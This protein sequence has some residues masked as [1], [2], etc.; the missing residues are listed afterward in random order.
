MEAV[1][2]KTELSRFATCALILILVCAVRT[3]GQE[4]PPVAPDTI[5][6]TSRDTYRLRVENAQYGRV[7]ISVDCG[8]HFMLVGRVMTP[9]SLAAADR[10]AQQAG[11]IVRS[12]SAGIA[13]AIGPGQVL[14]ILPKPA[15]A[16][17]LKPPACAIVTDIKARSLIFSDLG[18]PVGTV[19]LQQIGHTP[20]RPYPVGLTP[21]EDTVFAFVV[22]LPAVQGAAE[23]QAATPDPA[24]LARLT[25]VRGQLTAASE[26]YM[27][28]A[29]ERAKENKRAIVSGVVA[30]R[31]KLPPDEP[32]PITAVRYSI[33]GDIVSAQ[34]TFPPVYGWD[35]THLANGEHV[36]EICA[37]SKYATVVT[38]VRTLVVVQNP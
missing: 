37:L 21:T 9:A 29:A 6:I 5:A 14:K 35:T 12:T 22:N 15:P 36:V 33:D 13:F 26:Q 16:A 27:R 31:A 8:E 1:T 34:N 24:F 19:A 28:Q 2:T 32:E 18:P 20:W 30:L 38:R 10:E 23:A 11:T 7:E 3:Q 25:A 4:S 17:H